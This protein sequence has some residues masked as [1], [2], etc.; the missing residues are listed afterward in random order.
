MA[1][2][3]CIR[4]APRT[5]TTPLHRIRG[6]ET[7]AKAH[8]E[9]VNKKGCCQDQSEVSSHRGERSSQGC[10]DEEPERKR[11]YSRIFSSN[12]VNPPCCSVS[13]LGPSSLRECAAALARV[14]P[15]LSSA[16]ERSAQHQ[17]AASLSNPS[18]HPAQ[19]NSTH[20][21][22]ETLGLSFGSNNRTTDAFPGSQ[23][24]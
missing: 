6:Y 5:L 11:I 20:A 15:A 9:R 13:S 21:L 7:K 23:V 14:S 2:K 17:G 18:F 10:L 8:P 1:V 24:F 4:H 22:K 12:C 16:G 19:E 3:P